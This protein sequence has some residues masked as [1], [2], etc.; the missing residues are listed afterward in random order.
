MSRTAKVTIPWADGE[1]DFEMKIGELME[2]ETATR[3]LSYVHRNGDVEYQ[4]IG[5]EYLLNLLE[6]GKSLVS[7]TREVL[8][9]GLIGA[10]MQPEK[11]RYLIKRYVD[12]KPDYMLNR[13]KAWNVLGAALAGF[14]EESLGE[15]SEA[16][17]KT[18]PQTD[19]NGF[20]SPLS[21]QTP[22]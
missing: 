14:G 1:Y 19:S 22:Q 17:G 3:R 11:A 8:R 20:L 7:D 9:I 18:E 12:E 16:Q 21:T 6:T 2:L 15:S 5:A 13:Q 4:Y 10:G